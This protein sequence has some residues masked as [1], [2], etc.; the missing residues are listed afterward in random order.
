L[1]FF[2]FR[3]LISAVI[4]VASLV[5][6]GPAEAAA[7]CFGRR[8]TI[9]GTNRDPGRPVDLNGTPG[10][11]V[12]VGLR[13]WD[14]I[15]SRGGDDLVCG[16][17]GDDFIRTGAGIDRVMG[18]AGLDSIFGGAGRDRLW[19][20]RGGG[21]GLFGGPGDDR[22]FGG[23]GQEDSLIG[24]SGDDRI[25]GGPGYDLA[26]FWESRRGIEADLRTGLATGRGQDSLLF[27]EG[28]VGTNFDDAIYGDEFSNMLQGGP[29]NDMVQAFGTSADGG[30]DIL[31]SAG[32]NDVLDGGEGPDIV[33]YNL[34]PWPVDANLS[35]G[36]T[37][38]P[39]FGTDTLVGIEH[40]IGSKEIDTLIGDDND[41]MM[42]GNWG[43]DTLDGRGGVDEIA[44]FDALES[45]TADLDAGTSNGGT[46]SGMDRF[47]NFENLTGSAWRDRLR[48]D[49]GPNVILGGG[50]ADILRGRRDDDILVGGSGSD[51]AYGGDGTDE[52]DAEAQSN[53]EIQLSPRVDRPHWTRVWGSRFERELLSTMAMSITRP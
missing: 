22:V 8:A 53:C 42:V 40:L 27:I 10:D 5:V 6:A 20:G 39:G 44:F 12:I 28:I 17:G 1:R 37:T 21:D 51:T 14:I 46:R 30:I 41:N 25:S 11:D 29:G 23:R 45:V 7:K 9:V 13:G 50:S 15:R 16:G 24:G 49:D 34:V 33:S 43:D 3:I 4:V 47:A 18:Q 48:G 36:E 52:C 31:R 38:S 2:K 26:E 19:G 32:G 35:T